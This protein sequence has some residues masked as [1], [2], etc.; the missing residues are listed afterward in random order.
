MLRVDTSKF[1]N[2]SFWDSYSSCGWAFSQKLGIN[3]AMQFLHL[4]QESP[5]KNL[6]KSSQK[7]VLKNS[8]ENFLNDSKKGLLED[9]Q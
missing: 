8:Q 3:L 4:L 9:P 6:K 1:L 7:E 5:E 2:S